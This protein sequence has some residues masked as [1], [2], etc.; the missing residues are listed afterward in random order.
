MFGSANSN[1]PGRNL[2]LVKLCLIEP[3]LQ[4]FKLIPSLVLE[5]PSHF[6]RVQASHLSE[7]TGMRMAPLAHPTL[8]KCHY[9]QVMG[10]A[11]ITA[12]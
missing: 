7:K 2:P 10:K 12:H 1:I 6:H 11:A 5:E 4:H 9:G 8:Q 3:L